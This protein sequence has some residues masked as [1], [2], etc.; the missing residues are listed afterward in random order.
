TLR[1]PREAAALLAGGELGAPLLAARARAHEA[2]GALVA[3]LDDLRAASAADPAQ[4]EVAAARWR[5]EVALGARPPG[6]A[7]AAID[8]LQGGSLPEWQ[9]ARGLVLERTGRLAASRAALAEAAA[10]APR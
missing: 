10:L 2:C 9:R 6:E 5:L 8:A 3:A 7:L 1:R 4:V